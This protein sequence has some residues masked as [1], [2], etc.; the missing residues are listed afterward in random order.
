MEKPLYQA[1]NHARNLALKAISDRCKTDLFYLTKYILGYDLMTER[2]HGE[3]CALTT[4]LLPQTHSKALQDVE[5]SKMINVSPYTPNTSQTGLGQANQPPHANRMMEQVES[6]RGTIV[7]AAQNGQ[8]SSQDERTQNFLQG[9]TI[10]GTYGIFTG[11]QHQTQDSSI[12]NLSNNSFL[13]ANNPDLIQT[14]EYNDPFTSQPSTLTSDRNYDQFSADKNQLLLLMPRG[15]FKSSVVTIGFTL[16]ML[17]IDQDCRILID[18]ETFSKA[19]AFLAEVKGHLESNEKYREIYSYMYGLLPD[20]KKKSDIWS[21]NQLNISARKRPRKEPTISC[22]GV[23]VT[24]NG[25]HYDLIIMD[26]LHSEL[27]TQNKD[28]IDKVITHYKLA[29]S[30]LDPGRPLIIIGTRWDY[31]DVYQHI[32]DNES[33]NFNI[34]IRKAHNP[35]GSLFFPERLTEQ[36]LQKTRKTQGSYLFSCQYE[37]EP[38]DNES[39]TFKKSL[40]VTRP[41]EMVKDMPVNWYLMIDPSYDGPYSDYAALV[42]AGMNHQRDI[43]VRHVLR[44]KM[45]YGMIIDQM[46]DLYNRY[47]PRQILLETVAT[48]KSI[49]HELNNEQKRRNT[50]LPVTFVR[51]RTK[52][53]EER[54]RALAPFYEFGH[55]FHVKECNQLDELE[56]ELIHF[57]KGTHDDIIDALATVLEVA[58]PAGTK[59]TSAKKELDRELLS[60]LTKPRSPVTGI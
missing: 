37:N 6:T 46:F 38:V 16:Q 49:E 13:S 54:I 14:E 27:N 58:R 18:S 34:M 21:D 39:A 32:L 53:K 33:E 47:S 12:H 22:G 1:N 50:W 36:F 19:K 55:I 57:P 35:D 29:Y 8:T 17:L 20:A 45:T 10:S 9:P 43:Y 60:I 25:M 31:N 48:Q 51:T 3:L 44:K 56:Y 41:W 59:N 52:S 4:A 15:T 26:D 28:Q 11:S 23:D 40:M 7:S 30:L 24:K 2:T 42:V 5:V